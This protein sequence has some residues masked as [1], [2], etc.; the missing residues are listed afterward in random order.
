M[1]N[2]VSEERIEERC[3]SSAERCGDNRH[4]ETD[5]V[6]N[7]VEANFAETDNAAR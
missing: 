1:I 7:R 6:G 3:P 2:I 5:V 4:D